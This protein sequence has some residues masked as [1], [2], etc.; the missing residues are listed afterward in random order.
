MK[1]LGM[2]NFRIL[3]HV[4]TLA[5]LG[6]LCSLSNAAYSGEPE[7]PKGKK[8]KLV[9]RDEF[10]GAKV[11]ES[12][13]TCRGPY[14]AFGGWIVTDSIYLDGKGHLIIRT[15]EKDGTYYGGMIDSNGKFQHKYGY[16]VARCKL[17]REAGHFP[18]FWIWSAPLHPGAPEIEMD[19][20]ERGTEIDIMEY[21]PATGKSKVHH[22]LHWIVDRKGKKR[23]SAHH[24][25]DIPGVSEGYH[26]FAVEWTPGEYVFYVDGK[27]TWRTTKAV[28]H[29]A[30]YAC[31]SDHIDN[32]T[33]KIQDAKLP[34]FFEVDYVRVY[35]LVK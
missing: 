28:S 31:F 35:E 20:A 3:L 4:G 10:D 18:A 16:W 29:I 32:W 11:D 26:T 14:K 2:R 33:G 24:D 12:Q 27:I 5:L 25:V 9:W 22:N 17:S 6:A 8:W 21:F 1:G 34:D 15:Y 23:Q 7:L 19:P 13:W 30:Q